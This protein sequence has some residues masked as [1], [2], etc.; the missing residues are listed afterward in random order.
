MKTNRLIGLGC[1]MIATT[2]AL[3]AM[4]AHTLEDAISA[5]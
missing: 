2:V 5:R 1:L 3:G 4:G